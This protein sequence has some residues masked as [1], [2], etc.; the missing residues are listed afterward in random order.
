MMDEQKT[1]PA[2]E[3]FKALVESGGEIN[4][5]TLE[6]AAAALRVKRFE[7]KSDGELT[8]AIQRATKTGDFGAPSSTNSRPAIRK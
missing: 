4:R 7:E 6:A 8:S 1:H 2:V 5:E 3:K